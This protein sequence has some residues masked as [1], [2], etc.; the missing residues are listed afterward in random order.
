MKLLHEWV[1]SNDKPGDWLITYENLMTAVTYAVENDFDRMIGVLEIAT[2]I[3]MKS[4]DPDCVSLMEL[5]DALGEAFKHTF[6][7]HQPKDHEIIRCKYLGMSRGGFFI[8]ELSL[9]EPHIDE[10]KVTVYHF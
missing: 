10:G 8:F 4:S 6:K 5:V 9:Q 1:E 3:P 7:D 2:S